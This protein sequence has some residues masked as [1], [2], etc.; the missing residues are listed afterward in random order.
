MTDYLPKTNIVLN[1]AGLKIAPP[2]AG[3]KVTLLGVTSN[4]GIPLR[5]PYT[6]TSVE[7]A[8][9][10][11]YFSGVPEI[12][13][14]KAFP[15]ELARAI[16]EASNAGAPNIEV[17]VVG[18]YDGTGLAQQLDPD[19]DKSARY[20]ELTEAY[21]VLKNSN[22][23]V[24]VPLGIY[25]DQNAA[26]AATT[27][28]GKQLADFCYQSTKENNAC[29]GVIPTMPI[30]E[31]AFKY[32]N[33]LASGNATLANELNQTFFTGSK[34]ISS[35]ASGALGNIPSGVGTALGGYVTGED[36]K[37]ALRG[38]SFGVPSSTLLD[39]WVKYHTLQTGS[40]TEGFKNNIEDAYSI[41]Y[42]NWL[43]GAADQ[44]GNILS[45]ISELSAT[46]VNSNYFTYWQ[47]L[48]TD[49]TKASDSRGIQ[50]DAGGYISVVSA[51][52]VATLSLIPSFAIALGQRPGT[53]S[54][55]ISGGPAY[56]GLIN[57]LAPQSA[58]T[59]KQIQG[60]GSQ[61]L[62]SVSQANSL[63]GM[64]H[65]TMYNRNNGL[66]VARGITGSHNVT[67]YIR[68]DYV[69]LSTVRIVF[70]TI[71]LIRGVT[72][73]YIGEPNNA[74]QINSLDAEIDQLLQT[75]RS[76]GALNA[77]DYSISSTPEQRVLGQ[78]D[79]NLTLV[80]AFEIVE[81]NVVISLA[82]EI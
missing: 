63:V 55:N 19:R 7:K 51:P 26:N 76:Q 16:E 69:N 42:L 66:T 5:E 9:N 28:F 45:D 18:H 22:V 50:V 32:K 52:L 68:S 79:I 53:R 71:D 17:I 10:A 39:Q 73:K 56:A 48:N 82:D 36:F 6:I 70:A 33:Y 58:T 20:S 8:M 37:T 77:Y 61:R 2:P 40:L 60:V 81:I 4:S 54:V 12:N 27:T 1:D 34:T 57:T 13:G 21:S 14:G 65:V 35:T 59:N 38:M 80:P 46:S 29:V 43:N 11:L 3:P 23:D 67:R 62:L 75:L 15:G 47:A 64:R 49:G 31:W 30:M 25:A 44:D 72:N 78:L 41:G 74:P 24:V